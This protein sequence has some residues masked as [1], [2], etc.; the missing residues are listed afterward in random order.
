MQGKSD[1]LLKSLFCT[2]EVN[3]KKEQQVFTNSL[4][5]STA[6]FHS[7][8]KIKPKLNKFKNDQRADSRESQKSRL[9]V[10][11]SKISGHNVSGAPP[12]K[13]FKNQSFVTKPLLRNHGH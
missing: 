3:T 9:S 12:V 8:I 5:C 7:N 6:K 2:R 13:H 10:N 4:K 11:L 1:T